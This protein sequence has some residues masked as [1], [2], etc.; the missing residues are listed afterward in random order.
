MRA[1]SLLFG[2]LLAGFYLGLL[3]FALMFMARGRD[4][5]DAE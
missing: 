2:A 5:A 1:E 3:T 4:D